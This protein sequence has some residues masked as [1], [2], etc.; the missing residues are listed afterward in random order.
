MANSTSNNSIP[1]Q[2][3][4]RYKIQRVLGSGA[5]G[6]VLLAEDTTLDRPV[7][8]KIPVVGKHSAE[9]IKRRFIREA[10]TAAT[11]QHPNL[12]SVFD[13]G[14]IDDTFYITMAYIEGQTLTR[15]IEESDGMP[16]E[17]AVRLVRQIALGMQEAHEKGIVHRD[18]K[19]GNIMIDKR[20]EPIVMDFGLAHDIFNEELSRL[21]Q[22]GM[23][24]GTPAYMSPE[25]VNAK[26][27]LGPAS[28][29][30]SLGIIL[31]ELL[32]GQ[33]PFNGDSMML[34]G[35]IAHGTP[36]SLSE[37]APHVSEELST[38]CQHALEKEPERRFASMQQF[39]DAL[40]DY[41]QDRPLSLSSPGSSDTQYQVGSS[42][43]DTRDEEQHSSASAGKNVGKMGL[44]AIVL[45][46]GLLVGAGAS[47]FLGETQGTES[48][49]ENGTTIDNTEQQTQSGAPSLEEHP[50][51]A[52]SSW[53]DHDTMPFRGK[54]IKYRPFDAE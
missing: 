6:S 48:E 27:E 24:V 18:L 4:G 37:V 7:A 36:K 15:V 33:R 30:F 31:Y 26:D 17:E 23:A 13:V 10:R 50:V 2:T 20:G 40:D 41:L 47:Q 49:S 11:L 38:I 19:P 42:L 14:V 32:S 43:D 54:S 1:N 46:V 45:L 8:I 51:D 53:M 9:T 29:I 3:F 5:M 22:E 34:M 12:C 52:R 44:V 21:T 16:E 25:Q 35:Q 39:A 28:D